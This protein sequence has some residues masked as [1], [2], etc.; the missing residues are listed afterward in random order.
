MSF[1]YSPG[2]NALSEETRLGNMLILSFI[3]H[4]I[5]FSLFF[6]F[7]G[8]PAPSQI[9]SLPHYTSVN[10]VSLKDLTGNKRA[11]KTVLLKKAKSKIIAKK[12]TPI[13][14][15]LAV[16]KLELSK[17]VI[18]QKPAVLRKETPASSKPV[19]ETKKKREEKNQRGEERLRQ[20]IS[21]IKE[22]IGK[23][24]EARPHG[25]FGSGASEIPEMVVYTSIVVDRI[26]QAWF[27][28][29]KLKQ[30][31]L[32]RDLLT[33]INIR[34]D[35]DGKASFQGIERRSGNSLYDTFAL[36]AIKKIQSDSFPPLPEVFRKS[37]LDLGIRFH[38]SEVNP[39]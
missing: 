30:E 13:Q 3:F 32:D 6:F 17:M 39:S 5:A 11:G 15:K 24:V 23:E 31:A 20:A 19:K 34:I 26:M 7:P 35:K 16:K 18:P 25:P 28:P 33:V 9:N 1:F 27:L 21:E 38:P 14:K 2:K 10:L 22:K 29:P 12:P 36:A 4:L 37:Y 8:L